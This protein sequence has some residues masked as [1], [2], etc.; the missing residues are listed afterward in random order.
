M[1]YDTLITVFN[2]SA[3]KRFSKPGGALKTSSAHTAWNVN[4]RSSGT[5]IS[6]PSSPRNPM[7]PTGAPRPSPF[8]PPALSR[9]NVG[10]A[11]W[12]LAP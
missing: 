3:P 10:A 6:A 9:F 5:G 7:R 4:R 2:S 1:K 8:W 12:K 11:V